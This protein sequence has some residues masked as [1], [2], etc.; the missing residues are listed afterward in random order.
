IFFILTTT[1]EKVRKVLD[2]PGATAEAGKVRTISPEQAQK[3]TIMVTARL[4]KG[5]PVIQV[6]KSSVSLE[7]LHGVLRRA[8]ADTKKTTL[9][10]DAAKDVDYGVVVA[11]MDAARGAGITRT[12]MV[13]PRAPK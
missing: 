8:V 11:I 3:L 10:V 4:D 13:Q 9:L 1:Y 7:D 2:M 5:Q 12:L 6:E